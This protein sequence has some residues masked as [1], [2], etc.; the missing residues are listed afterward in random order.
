MRLQRALL[1]GTVATLL[2]IALLVPVVAQTRA[3]AQVR[4][5]TDGDW[6]R[7]TGDL[8][9]TRYSKL[10][11]INTSNVAN[12][13][14]AW[15]FAGVGGE[16]TAIAVDGVLY[17]T[18]STGVIALDGDTGKEVWRYG[19]V[20]A[21]A[22]AGGGGRGRG[23]GRGGAPPADAAAPVA[24]GQ[25]GTRGQGE[26]ARGAGAV[27]PAPGGAQAAGQ[28]PAATGARGGAAGGGAPSSRGVAYWPGDATHPARILAM[29]G[30]RL[31]AL[32]ASNGR[33]D[34]TFGQEGFADT[35]VNWG[36]VPLI[37]KN[38]VV[39]GAA[40]GEVTQGDSPG[41]TRAFDVR[42]GDKIWN[43]VSVAQPGDPN[44]A[45]A[46]LDD[47]WKRRQGVN[48]WGWYLTVDEQR[49]IVYTTF[50]SPAGNYWG[51]D[52]PGTN[53]Y[54][55]SVVAIDSNTGKY[56]WHFQ[57]VHHDLWDSDQPAAPTLIDIKQNGR[58]IPA[59]GLISKTA[60][61]FI[62][63]RTTGRPIFGVEE[64]PVPKG[65]VPGEWYSPTQPF[66]LKPPALAR[67][68][69]KKEDLVTAE[70]TTPE[71]AKA[72]IEAYE[73]A[74]GYYNAGPFTPFLFHEAGAPPTST[75]QFPG[76][77]GTNWGGPAGDPELGYIF[78]FTQDAALSGWIEKKVPGGNYGSGAGSPQPYD[79]GSVAGPGPYSGFSAG[80]PSMPCQKPPWGRLTAVNANSGDFAWQ[81]TLG[82][83]DNL[84]PGKQNTGRGGSAGPI[85]TAGGLV[86][87]G[88]TSD[89]RFRAIESKTGKELWVTKMN[90]NGGA[91]PMT[92]RGRSGKQYVA[93]A[94]G[95]TLNVYA[96][97]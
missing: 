58:T 7:Y 85:V 71:H 75:I 52:R 9:G 33:P 28:A 8:A 27:P 37:Y 46:W 49:D 53:L 26:P 47:G 72:C 77:G 11:Q 25:D 13:T 74:G 31:L 50:G 79:R 63:D 61:M 39:V 87:I 97:P 96:L 30:R 17:A 65:D 91:N 45:A 34:T 16:E 42:T 15:T 54:A 86:F 83:S 67:T 60:W 64:R 35:G 32:N 14:S 88:A 19:A 2:L 66:P 78:A 69:F 82:V 12:L 18:T 22:G 21:P 76:N 4:P 3:A 38:I 23:G 1:L 95:G 56:L 92:Y 51:G 48:H 43:F 55:N 93:Q 29:V 44:H 80:T 89:S 62:L 70:D 6:P 20:P 24:Q 40:N 84:P 10:K 81:I 73:R 36:G 94:A 41:D 90:G 68:S 5:F 59:L 57:S